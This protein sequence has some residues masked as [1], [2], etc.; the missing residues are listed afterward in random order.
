MEKVSIDLDPLCGH[1][2]LSGG[3][4]PRSEHPSNGGENSEESC[5][6]GSALQQGKGHDGISSLQGSRYE[7]APEIQMMKKIFTGIVHGV[8]EKI[9]EKKGK[10]DK[11]NK[12]QVK[13]KRVPWSKSVVLIIQVR[14]LHSTVVTLYKKWNKYPK[15][16]LKEL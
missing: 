13:Y 9:K 6:K 4:P 3:I 15:I 10:N 5:I 8:N 14:S 2:P 1:K 16:M 11:I 7:F 12:P